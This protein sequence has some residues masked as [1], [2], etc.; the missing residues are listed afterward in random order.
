MLQWWRTMKAIEYWE[1]SADEAIARA[2]FADALPLLQKAQV[3]NAMSLAS[4]FIVGTKPSLA[5]RE[6]MGQPSLS[7]QHSWQGLFTGTRTQP[8]WQ[9]ACC[10]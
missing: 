10:S 6:V 4:F 7:Q 8:V 1:K 9:V 5:C 2:A 3:S